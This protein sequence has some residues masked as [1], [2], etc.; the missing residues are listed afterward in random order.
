MLPGVH[1]FPEKGRKGQFRQEH[2]NNKQRVTGE[3]KNTVRW[4]NHVV[5]V[6]KNLSMGLQI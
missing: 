4:S 2:N 5:V 3:L 1:A 6:G